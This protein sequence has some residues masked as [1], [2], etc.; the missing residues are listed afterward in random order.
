M[1]H[2]WDL[3]LADFPSICAPEL[4]P[5]PAVAPPHPHPPHPPTASRCITALPTWR[6]FRPCPAPLAAGTEFTFEA[7]ISTSD[8]CHRSAIFS[9]AKDS[10][11]AD[12][13]QR[14]A[15]FN[16]FVIFDPMQLVACHDFHYM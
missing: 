14:I 11:A 4:G 15:D 8:Y 9:Y 12:P 7:W 10:M 5:A 2:A 13:D 6:H 1:W 16:H 3:L